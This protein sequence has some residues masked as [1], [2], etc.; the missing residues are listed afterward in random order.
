[1]KSFKLKRKNSVKYVVFS[2]IVKK[3]SKTVG[4]EAYI[5]ENPDYF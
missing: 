3:L 4:I 2:L 5:I 1:M